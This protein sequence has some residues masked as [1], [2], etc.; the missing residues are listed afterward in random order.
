[1]PLIK[2]NSF[3]KDHWTALPDGLPLAGAVDAIISFK[4][5]EQDWDEISL[6][7]GRVGVLLDNSS[8]AEALQ[9]AL[10]RGANMFR[11]AADHGF[12][13]GADGT[14]L[15]MDHHLVA[16]ALDGAADQGLVMA[17]AVIGRG[18]EEVDS[19]LDGAVDGEDAFAVVLG[20]VDARHGEAPKP[21][22]R[23]HEVA[24]TELHVFHDEPSLAYLGRVWSLVW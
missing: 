22:R 15:G 10:G 12:A 17:L 3:T 5:L 9:P 14:Q 1:M 21:D 8:D 7:N 19:E 4:R 24:G 11:R 16:A 20:A 23:D 13:V 6:H 2:D 18:I